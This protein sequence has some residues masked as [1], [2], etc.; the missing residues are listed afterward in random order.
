MMIIPQA[1]ARTAQALHALQYLVNH[2]KSA[3]PAAACW[4]L[5]GCWLLLYRAAGHVRSIV[6]AIW[7]V[8]AIKP[9]L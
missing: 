6:W 2:W 9:T 5:G 7:L 3:I 8:V 4:E 1:L